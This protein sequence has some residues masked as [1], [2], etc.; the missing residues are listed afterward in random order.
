MRVV[1]FHGSPRSG[2]NTELLLQEAVRGTGLEVEVFTLNTMNIQ[3]CQNCDGCVETGE[4]IIEDDM[5]HVFGAI[6]GADRIILAS[7]IFFMG[8]SAQ[9]KVMIDRCQ[10]LWCE[11][12]L[13]HREIP[14]G[15]HGRRGLVLLV[16]GMKTEKGV[17]C[18]GTTATAFFRSVSV[19]EHETLAYRQVDAKGAI[20]KHPSALREAFEAGR[21]LVS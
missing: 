14:A 11:K 4:C 8:V 21:K 19:P 15:K 3:P 2:G 7:P 16:G 6:R 13:L 20:T 1:A 17:A 9:A 5:V 12:Y 18:A 10:A